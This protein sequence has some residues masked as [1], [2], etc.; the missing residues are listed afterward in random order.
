MNVNKKEVI[1]RNCGFNYSKAIPNNSEIFLAFNVCAKC[2]D[3]LD[4]SLEKIKEFFKILAIDKHL[5]DAVRLVY[6][7]ELVSAVRESCIKLEEIVREKS[8]LKLK[9]ADL[10]AKAFNFEYDK[11]LDKIITPPL[12][13]LNE[14]STETLRNEQDGIKFMAMGVMRGIRNIY[15]HTKGSQKI[16]FCLEILTI[17]DFL[18]T[19]IIGKFGTIAEDRSFFKIIKR[20]DKNGKEV[21]IKEA[22]KSPVG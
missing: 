16:Y 12:I 8:G 19:N 15:L 18:I 14:L 9:G 21:T 13:A 10:M 5:S 22:I 4:H 2:G 7:S 3:L 11:K 17:I 6:K 20:K 1:C